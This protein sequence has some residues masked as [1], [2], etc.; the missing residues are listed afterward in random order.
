MSILLFVSEVK[1]FNEVKNQGDVS[2]NF[3]IIISN[4]G[5]VDFMNPFQKV[6]PYLMELSILS[7]VKYL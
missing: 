4:I 1:K 3:G 6:K 2:P 5:S 7:T